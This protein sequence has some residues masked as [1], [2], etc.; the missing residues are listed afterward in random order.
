MSA[1]AQPEQVRERRET[2]PEEQIRTSVD[3]GVMTIVLNRP[4]ALNAM[5]WAMYDGLEDAFARVEQDPEVRVVVLRSSTDR[6]FVA[7]TDISQF[8][9]FTS[10]LDGVEYERRMERFLDAIEGCRAPTVAAI[11]G[12]CVGGGF[13]LSAVCD[14]RVATTTARFGAPIARTLGNALSGRSV[15]LMVEHLGSARTLDILLRAKLVSGADAHAAGYLSELV[16]PEDLESATDA[17]VRTLLQHAP[18]TMWSVKETV[19]RLRAA[20]M[21]DCDDVLE[22]V[23]GSED[24][25]RG[26][27]A[28]VRKERADWQGD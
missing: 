23:Y 14:L 24:F 15:G 21:P 17:V 1:A 27:Q 20:G 6:A 26:V 18:L 5:T 28:F 16:E 12:F 10:G 3:G 7:G 13:L 8:Q 4:E 2:P 22:R 25:R 11:S 19:R 9:Q